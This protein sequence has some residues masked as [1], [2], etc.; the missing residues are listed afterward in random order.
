MPSVG[1]NQRIL[2]LRQGD[3]VRIFNAEGVLQD[4]VYF[5]PETTWPQCATGFGPTL[6]LIAP[7]LNNGLPQNWDCTNTNGS[8]GRANSELL[9]VDDVNAISLKLYPNPV[10]NTLNI[11]GVT[12]DVSLTFY[13]VLG[14]Q[15]LYRNGLNQVD[16]SSLKTGIYFLKITDGNK[17]YSHKIIKH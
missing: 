13:N 1:R 10:S 16:V 9:S 12:S 2:Q 15:V 5:N 7:D 6:E 17:T 11:K 14:K 3:A 4:E 8:P